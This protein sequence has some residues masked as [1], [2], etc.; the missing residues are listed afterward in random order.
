MGLYQLLGLERKIFVPAKD[1]NDVYFRAKNNPEYYGIMDRDYLTVQEIQNIRVTYPNLY[2]LEYYSIE[3]YLY[4]PKNIVELVPDF[5]TEWY[6]N[7]LSIQ[8]QAIHN[9]VLLGLK[10]ARNSYRVLAR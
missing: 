3:S 2:I 8:N 5:D 6:I 9:R 10:Q 4:H 1:K 7:E